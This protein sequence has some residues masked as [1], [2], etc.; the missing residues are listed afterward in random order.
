MQASYNQK[1]NHIFEA[2]YGRPPPLLL[3]L[4]AHF[5]SP[6]K[7][8]IVTGGT[9]K[10]PGLVI[11]LAEALGIEVQL[12]NPWEGMNLS[13]KEEAKLNDEATSYAVSVG[14]ALKPLGK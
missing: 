10:L 11:Y 3:T 2:I 5:E 1:E 13:S 8:I 7:R 14:L 6:V 12:G 4:H 9:A